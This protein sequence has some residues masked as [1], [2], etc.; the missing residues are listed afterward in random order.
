MLR[1]DALRNKIYLMSF[2]L[3][4]VLSQLL[5]RGR[6]MYSCGAVAVHSA[7]G[8]V[9]PMQMC[10]R[11]KLFMLGFNC[12]KRK[13][14]AN[15]YTASRLH[16][17]PQRGEKQHSPYHLIITCVKKTTGFRFHY[18]LQVTHEDCNLIINSNRT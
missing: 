3:T 11:I 5:N 2:N 13:N 17:S 14:R 16:Y 18:P 12:L 8:R 10:L 6:H 1:S 9:Q 4:V 7:C 15:P